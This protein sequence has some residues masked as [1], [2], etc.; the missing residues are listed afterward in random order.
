MPSGGLWTRHATA[1]LLAVGLIA[2]VAPIAAT[3]ILPFHDA[4]GIVGLG[5]ALAHR[6]DAAT[7]VDEFFRFDL[8]LMPSVLYFGWIAIGSWMGASAES[9]VRAFVA[10]FCLVGPVLATLALLRTFRRPDHLALL[11]LPVAYHHQV[12]FGFL[13]S[14]AAVS[15]VVLAPAVA[16]RVASRASPIRFVQ[17]AMVPLLAATAH[18]FAVALVLLEMTPLLVGPF[19][20]GKSVGQRLRTLGIGMLALAPTAVFLASWFIRFFQPQ[21]GSG[22]A[23]AAFMRQLGRARVPSVAD[24]PTLVRWLGGGLVGPIDEVVVAIAL[25]SLLVCLVRGVRP[26]APRGTGNDTPSP[27]AWLWPAWAVMV[28]A[29]GFLFLPDQLTWPTLWWGVRFRCVAP[30]FL[31]TLALVPVRPQGLRPWATWPAFATAVVYA[32]YLTWDFGAYFRGRVLAGFD[33]ALAVIAPGS[34]VLGL[35]RPPPDPH[36]TLPH[37][38]LVQHLVA[39]QGGRAA[40]YLRGHPGSYWVI[41]NR[42]PV[43]PSWGDARAFDWDAH[44]GGFGYF[45]LELPPRGSNLPIVDPFASLEGTKVRKIFDAGSWRVYQNVAPTPAAELELLPPS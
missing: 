28:L 36:H 13:G 1:C 35:P 32:A 27:R 42:M 7:R 30:L 12:W 29:G 3:P 11:A 9:A 41:Q 26:P 34:T 45:L 38:Y 20:P 25:A 39:R 5:G 22:S 44:A 37:P 4:S 23:W 40:P 6:G 19:T 31:M 18:P 24:G 33:G 17:A 14:A 15:A 43:S 10:V 16:F 8:G 2:L 21:G